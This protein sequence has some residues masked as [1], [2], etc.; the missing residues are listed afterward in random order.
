MRKILYWVNGF[1]K[2]LH[3]KCL[4]LCGIDIVF[5]IIYKMNRKS[6]VR[7]KHLITTTENS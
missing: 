2:L 1:W 3:K 4:Y 5:K 6:P 7:K